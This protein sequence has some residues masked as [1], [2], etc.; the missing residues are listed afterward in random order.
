MK[1]MEKNFKP[2]SGFLAL[3]L[4]LVLLVLSIYLFTQVDKGNWLGV[5]AIIALLGNVFLMKGLMIVQPNHSRVLT[6]FGKYVGS[7]KENGLFFVNPF[8]CYT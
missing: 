6:F 8:L 5:A 1:F 2:M 4:A 3:L 7:V